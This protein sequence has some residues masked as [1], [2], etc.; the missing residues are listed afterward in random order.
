MN[1][2]FVDGQEGTTGLQIRERLASHG[3]VRVLEIE[4]ERRKDLGRRRE[5]INEADLVFLCLPDAAARESVALVDPSNARTRIVDA[6]TAHRVADGWT[7]G[8]P[9]LGRGQRD[10][11]RASRR[12]ANPG[13]HAAGFILAVAPLVASDLLPRD[14]PVTCHSLTGYSGGGKSMIADYEGARESRVLDA[15][16]MYALG[17]T[18]KHLPEMMGY[19]GLAHAPVFVPI[20]DNFYKGMAVAVP[21]HLRLLAP[22]ATRA[23]VHQALA[24]HY[25][26]ERFVRVLPLDAETNTDR[27]FFDALA[28]NDTNRNDV[29]VFGNDE[30]VVVVSRLDN[31]GKGASGSAVQCMNL[32][33]GFDEGTAL[34]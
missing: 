1:T 18:H 13:C 27:G 17:Q 20:V 34:A 32:M 24:D 25:A 30:R 10:A 5:L 19:T 12:V 26:G 11:V 31:L 21:L 29:F 7:F 15:A 16:R 6:S 28:C 3:G 14:Y 22:G 23:R 8:L 4:A 9:E 33:L 2:V